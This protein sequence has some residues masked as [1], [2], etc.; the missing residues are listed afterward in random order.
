MARLYILYDGR[1]CADQGT[2]DAA[3][4]EASGNDEQEARKSVDMYGDIV[5]CYSYLEGEATA[6]DVKESG[7]MLTIGDPILTD[8]KWEWDWYRGKGFTDQM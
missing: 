7:G 8:E 3:V 6:E 1:A 5:A 4:M 2:E